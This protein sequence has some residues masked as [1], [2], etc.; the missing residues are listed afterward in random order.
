[1][2]RSDE[3]FRYLLTQL[4][5][6]APTIITFLVGL[7]LSSVYWSR[8]PRQSMLV[9]VASIIGVAT[10]VGNGLIFSYIVVDRSNMMSRTTSLGLLSVIT[11]ILMTVP[12]ILL[13]VAAL[14]GR[15]EQAAF[16]VQMPPPP[17]PFARRS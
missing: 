11:S 3:F 16:P 2:G 8:R 10:S 4:A 15:S 6:R 7:V 13:F 9:M 12:Y 17:P 1:M 5:Y 14:G